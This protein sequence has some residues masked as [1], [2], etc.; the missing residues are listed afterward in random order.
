MI[1]TA[2]PTAGTGQPIKRSV[3]VAIR[4]PGGSGLLLVQRPPDD[5]ELPGAWGLPAASLA[6]NETWEDA[7]ARAA[8]DKLGIDVRVGRELNRGVQARP[9]YTL[10]MRLYE[11]DLVAGEPHV[12]QPVPGVTQYGDWRWG[13]VE[14]VRPAAERG[15]LCS[16]LM[17]AAAGESE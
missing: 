17:L 2:N 14:A 1:D 15:S 13:D 8:R 5:A 6:E 7:V 11:A 12:P 10:E 4:P 9:G 16:Q 3:S